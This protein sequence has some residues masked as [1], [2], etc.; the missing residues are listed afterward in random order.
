MPLL[1]RPSR[2]A[3]GVRASWCRVSSAPTPGPDAYNHGLHQTQ[4]GSD[5]GTGLLVLG[6]ALARR[7]VGGTWFCAR[8]PRAVHAVV[9]AD[10]VRARPSDRAVSVVDREGAA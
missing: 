1:L 6:R 5:R 9:L 2:R 10:G 3:G 7:G 8:L 4:D